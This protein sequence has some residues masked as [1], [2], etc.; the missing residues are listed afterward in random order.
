M[1]EEWKEGIIRQA[2]AGLYWN[3]QHYNYNVGQWLRDHD[4]M[5][6]Q[7]LLSRLR[8]SRDIVSVMQSMGIQSYKGLVFLAKNPEIVNNLF[9]KYQFCVQNALHLAL[10]KVNEMLTSKGL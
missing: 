5:M 4:N 6:F 9:S 3:K 7:K 8:L 1:K 2:Y 10:R